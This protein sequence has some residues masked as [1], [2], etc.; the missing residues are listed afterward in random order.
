MK[1]G[2][3]AMVLLGGIFLWLLWQPPMP[4]SGVRYEIRN[5]NQIWRIRG[6]F[7]SSRVAGADLKTADG[8]FPKFASWAAV[9]SGNAVSGESPGICFFDDDGDSSGFLRLSPDVG[10]RNVRMDV[11]GTLILTQSGE[12]GELRFSSGDAEIP[13]PQ[14][15]YTRDAERESLSSGEEPW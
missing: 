1:A 7:V 9:E 10:I 11:E 8:G 6:L 4:E 3:G 12:C 15:R 2:C 13:W 14:D 5:G